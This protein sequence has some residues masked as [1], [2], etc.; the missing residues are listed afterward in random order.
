MTGFLVAL[1][2]VVSASGLVT[3]F[4]A[5][6]LDRAYPPNGRLI[7]VDGATVHLVEHGSPSADQP[8]LLFVHGASSN[9]REFMIALEGRLPERFGAMFHALYVDRPGQG[10]SERQDGD[11]SPRAQADRLIAAAR[12]AGATGIIAVGHSWGGAVVAQMAVHHSDIVD[13][14]VFVAPATHPWPGGVDWFYGFADR[15]I[16]GWLFTRLV[17]LPAGWFQ[18]KS[19][20]EGVFAPELPRPDYAE[21]LIPRLVLRPQAFRANAEDV[22]RLKQFVTREASSYGQIDMPVHIITGNEDGVVW[23]HIHSVGL[24]RDI[25]GAQKI[26]IEGGGHMPHQTH[27]ELVLDAIDEIMDSVSRVAEPG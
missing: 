27:P 3:Q 21:Q 4:G 7:D 12:A 10:H 22:Y 24:E 9:H 23:P 16:L 8:S 26:V 20:V 25:V 15:P 13:G 11:H 2:V 19:G 18:V 14:A 6:W 17:S 5:A 1:L